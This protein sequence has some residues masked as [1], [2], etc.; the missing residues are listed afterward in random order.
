MCEH[1]E[2]RCVSKGFSAAQR[3]L[4]TQMWGSHGAQNERKK[5]GYKKGCG[6]KNREQPR[7]S[8]SCSPAVKRG[9][10]G[11]ASCRKPMPTPHSCDG[12]MDV[13]GAA[14]SR[15]R[16]AHAYVLR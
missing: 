10:S 15:K 11:C 6:T 5:T 2:D 12:R 7:T 9:V 3:A 8:H 16:Y 1:G 4:N 13:A 14:V